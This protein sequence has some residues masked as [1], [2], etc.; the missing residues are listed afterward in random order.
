MSYHPFELFGEEDILNGMEKR[1]FSAKCVSVSGECIMIKRRDL[2]FRILK[3]EGAHAYLHTRLAAKNERMEAKIESIRT[4]LHAFSE[5]R[6]ND[7][8]GLKQAKD[9][10]TCMLP[11][12]RFSDSLIKNH[13]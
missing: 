4:S 12:Q 3:D 6:Y 7:F 5:F 10:I 13:V 1:T 9:V 8:A 2:F 11:N